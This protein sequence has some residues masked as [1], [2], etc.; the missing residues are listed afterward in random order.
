MLWVPPA[1]QRL[2][3]NRPAAGERNRWLIVEQ[4]L[5][6]RD[7]VTQLANE[8]QVGGSVLVVVGGVHGGPPLGPLGDIHRHIRMAH[9]G[10]GLLAVFR[11]K[12]NADASPD[13]D[14]SAIDHKGLL[15]R[16]KN[17][18]SGLG[19]AIEVGP[20]GRQHCE[21]VSAKPR[22]RVRLSEGRGQT[23]RDLLQEQIAYVV[24]ERIVDFLE[25]VHIHDEQHQRLSFPMCDRD[26]LTQPV[27]EQGSVWQAGQRIVKRLIFERV[28][29]GPLLGYVVE[30]PNE[31]SFPSHE[32]FACT[33]FHWERRPILPPSP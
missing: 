1:H 20:A 16:M 17:L 28:L 23:Q 26:A 32:H 19:S 14:V 11:A 22:Y 5:V 29:L 27:I 31:A 2:H 15:Q 25:S 24:T 13:I 8:C 6:M 18:L 30:D 9:E 4:Q 7:G 12:G 33:E 10:V 21:F 3:P